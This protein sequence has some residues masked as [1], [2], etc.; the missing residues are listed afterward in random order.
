MKQKSRLALS[1]APVVLLPGRSWA[2]SGKV[3]RVIDSIT[4]LHNGGGDKIRLYGIDCPEKGQDFGK[5][6]EGFASDI[7]FHR[8]VEAGCLPRTVAGGRWHWFTA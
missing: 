5:G 4:V 3:I 2:W 8:F 6:A 7:V 1:L